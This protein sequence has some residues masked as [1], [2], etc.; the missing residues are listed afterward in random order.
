MLTRLTYLR[1]SLHASY[2][3]TGVCFGCLYGMGNVM[4]SKYFAHHPRKGFA[5]GLASVGV[6]IGSLTLPLLMRYIISTYGLRGALQVYGGCMLQLC[7]ATAVCRP[8]RKHANL[9]NKKPPGIT[10][11]KEKI[12]LHSGL[13]QGS[14]L[15][16]IRAS[17]VCCNAK[18]HDVEPLFHFSLL[19]NHILIA[20]LIGHSLMNAGYMCCY[21]YLPPYAMQ[22][23]L[24]KMD[25]SLI[26]TIGGVSDLLARISTGW[27]FDLRLMKAYNLL[28][29]SSVV[30]GIATLV[31]SVFNIHGFLI[32][33]MII[34]SSTSACMGVAIILAIADSVAEDEITH[35][36]LFLPVT[37]TLSSASLPP[38]IGTWGCT[39][40]TPFLK[41]VLH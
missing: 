37:V 9:H 11:E 21:L 2:F 17:F 6:S 34:I 20:M 35:A 33:F 4:V 36:F 31:V 5:N 16:S 30:G 40:T 10:S 29:L 32:A 18:V 12:T 28:A 27:L 26:L 24:S 1:N 39:A 19:Q 14:L 13:K 41:Q 7:V 38:L 3:I 8:V 22:I 25:T 15:E 23:G